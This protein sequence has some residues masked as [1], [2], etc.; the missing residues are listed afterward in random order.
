MKF[1]N[2]HLF[3][4]F[5]LGSQ[6]TFAQSTFLDK[7]E[8]THNTTSLTPSP[9]GGFLLA[10]SQ[11]ENQNDV[12]QLIQYD[13]CD[14]IAFTKKISL[15]N[16]SIRYAEI[17]RSS[18]GFYYL[19]GQ[20][21][22]G[23]NVPNLYVLKL[24]P[25]GSEVFFK[26]MG[27]PR[28]QIAYSIQEMSN[29]NLMLFGNTYLS[30]T[31]NRN[32]FLVLDQQGNTISNKA[33]FN[34]PVWG[35]GTACSDG[36]LGKM[37]ST[38]YKV[39]PD[40]S[41]DWANQ[42]DEIYYSSQ[43]LEVADG[44]IGV[45]FWDSNVILK[46]HFLYKLKK[47]GELDWV[48]RGYAAKGHAKLKQLANGNFLVLDAYIDDANAD[49]YFLNLIEF[50]PT[51]EQLSNQT[52]TKLYGLPGTIAKHFDLLSDGSVAFAAANGAGRDTLFI[53]KT[54]SNFELD[55]SAQ[56]NFA[57][58]DFPTLTVQPRSTNVL[59][60]TF[61]TF[62]SEI[63]IAPEPSTISRICESNVITFPSEQNDTS[64][65]AG[66]ELLLDFSMLG[67][68][69]VWQ[70]GSNT[71]S[72]LVTQGG[73]YEVLIEK[74]GETV[75]RTIQVEFDECPCDVKTPNA[76]TPDGDG[77]NDNFQVLSDCELLDFEIKIF[78]RWG[79]IVFQSTDATV[80]WNGKLDG[81][82]L[83]SDVYV[84]FYQYRVSRGFNLKMQSE[85]GDVTLIR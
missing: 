47:N 49:E 43:L 2:L 72:Y 74:C 50:S 16:H 39:K 15:P 19:F 69:Y 40:G 41:L 23:F 30:S 67:A 12:V 62:D 8:I 24:N 28:S 79:Q 46:P 10:I 70:D 13:E 38:I 80:S 60:I 73:S 3:L 71:S 58:S 81:K 83:T 6:L 9:D 51:G 66:D 78:N 36:F 44:Y 31:E 63:V 34:A 25:D 33:Y 17:I 35:Y 54:N 77:V 26:V 14:N 11:R 4:L 82:N 65:C 64:I 76:F 29:G 53:G 18:D 56:E 20:F 45:S 21:I 57:E 52:L 27:N 85:R 84:Y 32:F 59:D 1:K 22:A 42:Y 37:G 7:W 48:S 61:E 68:T 75:T 5:L 55:C